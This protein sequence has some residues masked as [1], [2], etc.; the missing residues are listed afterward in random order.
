VEHVEIATD[1]HTCN[2]KPTRGETD[3]IQ[4]A[5]DHAVLVVAVH[6][7]PEG[8]EHSARFTGKATS[9]AG[10]LDIPADRAVVHHHAQ[11]LLLAQVA[12]DDARTGERGMFWVGII[13]AGEALRIA[14]EQQRSPALD[15][16]VPVHRQT[17]AAASGAVVKTEGGH[18]GRA[19][20]QRQVALDEGRSGVDGACALDGDVGA[21]GP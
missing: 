21:I 13:Y 15:L 18:H 17:G 14:P 11:R 2:P 12:G 20:A 10:L 16:E 1:V 5:F 7:T 19:W 4:V 9:P 8:S 6:G 3:H